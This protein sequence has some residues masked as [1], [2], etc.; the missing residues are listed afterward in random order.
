MIR[1]KT[2]GVVAACVLA[3]LAVSS[4][5]AQ[6]D[7]GCAVYGVVVDEVS[8]RGIG[9]ASVWV[10]RGDGELVVGKATSKD[11]AFSFDLD[12]CGFTV[13]RVDMLGY[14]SMR[15]SVE[16]ETGQ[17]EVQMTLRLPR[18]PL[19]LQELAVAIPRSLRLQRAGFY[20]RRAWVESTGQDYANFFGPDE[21]RSRARAQHTVG[22]IA[23]SSRIRTVYSG[24][25]PSVY[26]NGRR[27]AAP[28][29][30]A[31]WERVDR[32][33]STSDVEGI[34][35]Y[36]ALSVAVPEE[37]RDYDSTRCGAVVVWTKEGGAATP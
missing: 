27:I 8:T 2:T 10:E 6:D 23:L 3:C 35:I 37:F 29:R 14:E 33:V 9:G 13:V 20:A 26:L 32:A 15:Q 12:D 7:R 36:R 11:G 25:R 4:L 17:V 21:V 5:E 18:A 30:R 24:C 31:L 16:L 22:R 1:G 34:E 28:T 19:Q